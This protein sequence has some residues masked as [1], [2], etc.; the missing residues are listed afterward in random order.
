MA[1]LIIPHEHS[2]SEV[3][4]I[5]ERLSV[6][7]HLQNLNNIK[8]IIK[9]DKNVDISDI[10]AVLIMNNN[11]EFIDTAHIGDCNGAGNWRVMINRMWP[12][13][14]DGTRRM[15]GFFNAKGNFWY[16]NFDIKNQSGSG[17]LYSSTEHYVDIPDNWVF[18]ISGVGKYKFVYYGWC[19]MVA[20]A[21]MD[22]GHLPNLAALVLT[23]LYNAGQV[24]Q[25]KQ[26]RWRA[27]TLKQYLTGANIDL[28]LIVNGYFYLLPVDDS[29]PVGV[30]TS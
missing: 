28:E 3:D 2:G 4:L 8:Q 18:N 20:S 24:N 27:E 19:N 23:P 5:G 29:T 12:D 14:I 16:T 25:N 26:Y 15:S 1:E 17:Y 7:A 13:T 10:E 30:P 11:L 22:G 9:T 21:L 6:S